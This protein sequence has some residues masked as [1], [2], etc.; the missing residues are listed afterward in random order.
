[1]PGC[2]ARAGGAGVARG[3]VIA[4]RNPQASLVRGSS[5]FPGEPV[6]LKT[7]YNCPFVKY[8][9]GKPIQQKIANEI[10]GPGLYG[11]AH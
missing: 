2:A 8:S 11:F 6:V 3:A 5:E 4:K 9:V 10:S 1:M 7:A